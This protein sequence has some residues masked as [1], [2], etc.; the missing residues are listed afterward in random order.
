MFP[1]EAFARNLCQ[2]TSEISRSAR[3]RG[4][5][6]RC[7]NN[8]IVWRKINLPKIGTG[9]DEFDSHLRFSGLDVA[10]VDHP[11][12]AELPAG[13]MQDCDGFADGD[14]CLERY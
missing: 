7:R 8:P 6:L 14:V 5:T 2:R 3:C 1:T 11:A 4:D 13:L 9:L 10:Y 12:F